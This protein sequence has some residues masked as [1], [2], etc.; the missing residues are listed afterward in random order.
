MLHVGATC[1]EDGLLRKVLASQKTSQAAAWCAEETGLF[2]TTGIDTKA[3]IAELPRVLEALPATVRREIERETRRGVPLA[4]VRELLECIGP[5][6]AVAVSLPLKKS[7]MPDVTLLVRVSDAA[8]VERMLLEA[9]QG[10]AQ[11]GSAW[12]ETE[13]Q[14]TKIHYR[15]VKAGPVALSPCFATKDGW[16]I[17]SQQVLALKAVLGRGMRADNPIA[18]ALAK[19]PMQ[20]QPAVRIVARLNAAAQTYYDLALSS[21]PADSGFDPKVLPA[22]EEL[23]EQLGDAMG[24]V[25]V[26]PGGITF[27]ATHPGSL[28][29]IVAAI[30]GIVDWVLKKRKVI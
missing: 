16:L 24:A 2:M 15:N 8:R 14:G 9:T 3:L 30:G 18:A 7:V 21:V 10:G 5:E 28:A 4:Q 25:E 12:K 11:D 20:A 19:D 22:K 6:V 17:A 1:P 29:E 13:Y 27:H 26:G 23:Q